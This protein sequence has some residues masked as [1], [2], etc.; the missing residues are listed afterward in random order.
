[1]VLAMLA[2]DLPRQALRGSLALYFLAVEGEAVIGEDVDD[3]VPV[4]AGGRRTFRAADLAAAAELDGAASDADQA[5]Q[6]FRA[7][8]LLLSVP[9]FAGVVGDDVID[10]ILQVA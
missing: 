3:V 2:K 5:L 4:V 6:P 8:E 1:M 10:C 9:G 7:R